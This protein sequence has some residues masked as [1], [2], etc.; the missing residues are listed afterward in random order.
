MPLYVGSLKGNTGHLESAA[1]IAGLMKAALMLHHGLLVPTA[2]LESLNPKIAAL[3]SAHSF[4]VLKGRTVPLPVLPAAG[5]KRLMGI[6][7]YGFGGSNAFCILEE[8]LPEPNTSAASSSAP[9][10]LGPFV[11]A[12]AA[13]HPETLTRLQQ[14][15]HTDKIQPDLVHAARLFSNVHQAAFRNRKVIIGDFKSPS[16]VVEGTKTSSS[17]AAKL[18]YCF[19]GQGTQYPAMGAALYAQFEIFRDVIDALDDRYARLAGFSLRRQCGFCGSRTSSTSKNIFKWF[20]PK[21]T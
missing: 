12:L 20:R 14:L 8:I 4:E 9:N 19:D 17:S 16:N 10:K 11:L 15:W 3:C 18:V 7:S 1:G 13:Q 6:N 21:F 2:N 5:S